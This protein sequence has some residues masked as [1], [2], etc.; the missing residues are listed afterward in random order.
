MCT[1][2]WLLYLCVHGRS[3]YWQMAC[4]PWTERS[5]LI[6]RGRELALSRVALPPF[7]REVYLLGHSLL[8]GSVHCPSNRCLLYF[9]TAC[10]AKICPWFFLCLVFILPPDLPP[11]HQWQVAG[12]SR[13]PPSFSSACLLLCAVKQIACQGAP[14]EFPAPGSDRAVLGRFRLFEFF[15]RLKLSG[16]LGCLPWEL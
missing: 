5:C 12:G 4:S 8:P 10:L 2:A 14:H 6:K 16:G 9:C 7:D 13:P 15:S 3:W 11:I 1:R